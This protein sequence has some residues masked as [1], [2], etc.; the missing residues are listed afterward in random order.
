MIL[1]CFNESFDTDANG[2]ATGGTLIWAYDVVNNVEIPV[3]L[4][5]SE[6]DNLGIDPIKIDGLFGP[7]AEFLF[8]LAPQ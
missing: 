6:M 7:V 4:S 3:E 5:S 1:L 8:S 2:K